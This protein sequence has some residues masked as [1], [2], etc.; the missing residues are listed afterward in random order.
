MHFVCIWAV[1]P[2]HIQEIVSQHLFVI[3]PN[4]FQCSKAH[5]LLSDHHLYQVVPKLQSRSHH[6]NL[7][8]THSQR[9]ISKW[10]PLPKTN[11][12]IKSIISD[13]KSC[14]IGIAHRRTIVMHIYVREDHI[15]GEIRNFLFAYLSCYAVSPV[16][17]SG[18][19]L[20]CSQDNVIVMHYERDFI[21]LLRPPPPTKVISALNILR[22]STLSEEKSG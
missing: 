7:I 11:P 3:P 13:N 15:T 18:E 10:S 5:D 21:L 17:F 1:R 22:L 4:V 6:K 12:F 16:D 20:Y 2:C 9:S 8:K 19:R 14:M